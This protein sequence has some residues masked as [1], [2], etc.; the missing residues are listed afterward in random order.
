MNAIAYAVIIAGAIGHILPWAV[1]L[2]LL[3][4]PR[5]TTQTRMVLHDTAPDK[6][7]LAWF[8][9]VQLHMEFGLLMIAGLL[10][11]TALGK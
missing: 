1:L 9:G 3:T 4:L 8:R 7:N 5:A 11:A 2:V 6:L 10:L